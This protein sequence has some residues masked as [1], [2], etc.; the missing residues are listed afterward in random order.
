MLPAENLFIVAL[1]PCG[2]VGS[3]CVHDCRPE[4]Q[5]SNKQRSRGLIPVINMDAPAQAKAPKAKRKRA[6]DYV[7]AQVAGAEA[8]SPARWLQSWDPHYRLPF[9]FNTETQVPPVHQST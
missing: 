5:P 8:G 6:K 9:Y 4:R 7:S 1:V 2:Y 3:D